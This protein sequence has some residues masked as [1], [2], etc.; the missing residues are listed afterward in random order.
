M[1]ERLL[2]DIIDAGEDRVR[3]SLATMPV[4]TGD[5]EDSG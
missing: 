1:A 4:S 5:R 3:K 2:N